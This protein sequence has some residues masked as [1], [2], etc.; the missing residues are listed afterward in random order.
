VITKATILLQIL[1]VLSTFV[2]QKTVAP[3]LLWYTTPFDLKSCRAPKDLRPI[4]NIIE[5][6]KEVFMVAHPD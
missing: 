1:S 2:M 3:T 4:L 6:I 5:K